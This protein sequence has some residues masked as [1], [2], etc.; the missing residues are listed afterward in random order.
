[1]GS[2]P[3]AKGWDSTTQIQKTR[4]MSRDE[5][6]HSMRSVGQ[7]WIALRVTRQESGQKLRK[8]GEALEQA[9]KLEKENREPWGVSWGLFSWQFEEQLVHPH[10]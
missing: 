3:T 1:M 2:S 9:S 10:S 4:K 6:L 5:G 7:S 8:E